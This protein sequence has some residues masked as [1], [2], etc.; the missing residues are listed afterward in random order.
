M[1]GVMRWEEPPPREARSGRK[2]SR[3]EPVVDA[4][5]AAPGR[6]AVVFEGTKSSVTT[7]TYNMR[8]GNTKY[9]Q[10]AGDFE[11]VARV[12]GAEGK[13]YARFVG[14]PSPEVQR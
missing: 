6:W 10:P 13:I 14:E 11:F 4:L 1:S 8:T 12:S 3:Y 9:F 2:G 7:T 5:K